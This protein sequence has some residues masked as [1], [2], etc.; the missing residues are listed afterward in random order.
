[1]AEDWDLYAVV[2]SC[3]TAANTTTA[4]ASNDFTN[5]NSS[6]WREDSLACLASLTFEEDD[7]FSFPNLSQRRKSGS[8]QDSYKPFLPYADPTTISTNQGIDPS[9][10]SS[11][12]GGSSGQHHQ[13]Q[14]VQQQQE[15]PTTTT[16]GIGISSPLTPT[17]NLNFSFGQSGNQ[18]QPHH[19]Q[20]QPQSQQ[21]INPLHRQ[22]QLQQPFQPQE[23]QRPAAVLLLRNMQSQAPRSRKR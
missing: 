6:S 18:Q 20:E 17:S 11:V 1:M 16:S 9:S 13:H 15:Q 2:R 23:V 8:L 5:E 4:T 10:S 14:R 21:Q 12:P 7:L 19:V 3:T 22:Q